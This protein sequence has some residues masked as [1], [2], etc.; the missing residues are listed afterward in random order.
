MRMYPVVAGGT[1]R[2]CDG[3]VD[4]VNGRYHVP[5]HTVLWMPLHTIHNLPANFEDAESFIPVRSIA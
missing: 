4:L 1:L 3:D 5:G 2:V